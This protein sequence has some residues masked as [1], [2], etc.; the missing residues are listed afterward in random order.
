MEYTD[1]KYVSVQL[2]LY[3]VF[4]GGSNPI[5]LFERYPGRFALVHVKDMA[6]T[7]DEAI[8]CVGD[9]RIDFQPLL[10]HARAAGVRYAMVEH[11]RSE[12]GLLCAQSSIDY[13]K[14][15]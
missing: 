13:L 8:T 10:A 7:E 15:L 6:R 2:D 9:G 14:G 4:K 12:N 5:E 3:W 1:P 11:E